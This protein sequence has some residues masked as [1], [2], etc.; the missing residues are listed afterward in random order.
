MPLH[1]LHSSFAGPK[2]YP[3]VSGTL[4]FSSTCKEDFPQTQPELHAVL[5]NMTGSLESDCLVGN[6]SPTTGARL[7]WESY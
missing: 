6:P 5:I 1:L 7:P 3:G 2:P 4:D